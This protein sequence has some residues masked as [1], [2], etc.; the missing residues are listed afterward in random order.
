MHAN[1]STATKSADTLY[2]DGQ[3]PICSA[4]IGRLQSQLDTDLTCVDIHDLDT[5]PIERERLFSELHL[6]K[7]DGTWLVGLQANVAA[8][9]HTRWR[10]LAQILLW[11]GVRWVADM[12][13]RL[14]LRWYQAQ[15]AAR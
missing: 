3:C 4:E 10:S 14:W 15:R 11:P 7:A 8:W 5:T 6:Q 1:N 9:Q 2:F 13:Y 12:G